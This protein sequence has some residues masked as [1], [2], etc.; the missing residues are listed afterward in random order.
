MAHM[1]WEKTGRRW[2]VFW[3]VTLPDGTVDKGSRSFKDKKTASEFKK[4]CEKKEKQLKRAVFVQPVYLTDALDEWQGFCQGYTEQTRELYISEVE[5]F[6]EY[7]PDSV[8][9]I[10]DLTKFHINS[11]L[12][13][14]MSRGLVNKTVNN[15]MCAIKSLC[16]YVHENYSITN[17]SKGIKK[18]KEDP[19][20][21]YFITVAEYKTVLNNCPERIR[22]WIEFLACTGL[23]ATEFCNLQWRNCDLANKT[24]TIVGKGRKRRTIGLNKTT[25]GI[26]TD[27]KSSR[28]MRPSDY[29]FTRHN[30][31]RL[32]RNCLNSIGKACRNAGLAGGGPQTFRHFFATQLLLR[33]I[34]IIKVSI[35][36]GHST[37][38]TT[39]RCYSH[40][41][42][43]DLT[44][45]TDVLEAG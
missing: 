17:P 5:R 24:I 32:S 14:Q 25:V 21:V 19:A 42:S 11:Y 40:I 4:H 36:M 6:V 23:R 28:K 29:V 8:I 45:V 31:K 37:V 39:Q 41:L 27:I 13:Y 22:P 3:H 33:G 7:L 35:L 16:V 26:L 15:S 43:D 18:L 30:G 12:N 9:Y 2:R 34:P 44:G 10:T 38:T 1:G 20:D